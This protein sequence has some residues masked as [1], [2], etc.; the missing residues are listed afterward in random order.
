MKQIFGKIQVESLVQQRNKL[1]TATL[2][3]FFPF[4]PCEM[5]EIF[6]STPKEAPHIAPSIGKYRNSRPN[7]G[8][9]NKYDFLLPLKV[10]F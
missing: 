3:P 2:D 8:I 4:P 10:I 9:F 5:I 1:R 7:T 6:V